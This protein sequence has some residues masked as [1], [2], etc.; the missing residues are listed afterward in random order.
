VADVLGRG[1]RSATAV[2]GGCISPAWRVTLEG[3]DVAF[4]KSAPAGAPRG[5]L[6]AEAVSLE[7]LAVAGA[8]RVPAVIAR[9]DEWLA[10]E[11][12]EPAP[13]TPRGWRALGAG[14]ASLHRVAG[15]AYGWEADN[16][17]GTLPQ[18]NAVL[19]SWPEFWA[20][21]RLGPQ[22][23]RAAGHLDAGT[24]RAFEGLLDE[25]PARL[26]AAAAEPASL[27]HG[28]L[29]YGNVHMA[30]GGPALID[31]SSYY[32][33]RE[34]DLAMAR[35]FG[36]FDTEFFRAYEAEWPLSAGAQARLP[37]YQ[38]YYLLVHVNLFGGSYVSATRQ[39]LAEALA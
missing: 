19:A 10:L 2:G 32:G 33:H 1:I 26:A 34:V 35:L 30:S 37:I 20:V 22:L 39:A 7:R 24:R 11:W 9:A 4:I 13:A 31:P 28:D 27:L 21:R 3:G 6:M 38:L 5:L 16:F 36:G 15:S 23:E 18:P 14:L 12:L 8:V 25:L 17:I 29:W